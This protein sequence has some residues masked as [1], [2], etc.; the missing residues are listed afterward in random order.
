[1]TRVWVGIARERA[2][3]GYVRVVLLLLNHAPHL[4]HNKMTSV[5]ELVV[6]VWDLM[7]AV[8]IV[9]PVNGVTESLAFLIVGLACALW[10]R[11]PNLRFA[12]RMNCSVFL[13]LGGRKFSLRAGHD[14]SGGS[15]Q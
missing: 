5:G 15:S 7:L 8:G 14:L 9:P 6:L 13:Q 11:I 2:Y 10:F 12:A 1:M 4:P 3:G